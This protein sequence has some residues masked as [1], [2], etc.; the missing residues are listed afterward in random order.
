MTTVAD[1]YGVPGQGVVQQVDTITLSHLTPAALSKK[2]IVSYPSAEAAGATPT[3][4]VIAVFDVTTATALVLGTD[5]TLTASGTSPETLTYSVTRV[6][7]SSASADADTARVTYR[8]G[9]QPS[10]NYNLGEFQGEAGAAPAGTAFKGSVQPTTG[11]SA[12]GIGEQPAGGSLTDPANA[13]KG[14]PETGSPGSEY[15]VTR[16]VP[17]AFGWPSGAPDTEGVYGGGLPSSFTPVDTSLT[18]TLDTQDSGGSNLVPSMYSSPPGY[19]APSAGVAGGVKET[20][21][22]EILGN[23]VN[24]TAAQPGSGYAA[25]QVDTGYIGSPAAPTALASQTDTVTAAQAATP[26]Y[27]SKLGV[28]PSSIVVSDTTTPAT[29]VLNTDYTVTTSGDGGTT[30][31]YIT[32][33]TGT[34]FTAS[35]NVSITYSWGDSTYWGSNTPAAPPAAPTM[36]SASAVNRGALVTWAPPAGTTPVDFYLLAAEDLGTMYVPNTGMPIEYGQPSPSGGGQAGEPTYQ[37]DVVGFALATPTGLAT[38]TVGTAGSTHYGY[39]V[40]AVGVSGETLA[41]AEVQL[42]TGNATLDGT[43]YN[44]LAW[45]A[46]PGAAGYN[47]YGRTQGAELK[48]TPAPITVLVFDD[49]GTVTPAGALPAANTT[50]KLSKTG[51]ITPPGQVIVRD[52]VSVEADPMQPT[53]TVLEYGY[54]YTI[55]QAGIGPWTAYT[56]SRAAG[57]VNSAIGDALIAEYWW[58]DP[59]SVSAVFTQGL[60]PNTPVI[61]KPDG[62]TPYTQGYRFRVAAGNKAGLG[63]WSAWSSYVVP[64]NYNEAQPGHEGSITVGTGSLDPA[65][66]VNPIYNPDGTVKAGTGLGG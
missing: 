65:N 32:L 3:A 23:Q 25:A 4:D 41:C 60:L 30:A 5:Y 11:S 27:L 8:Y 7:S 44:H 46:V 1:F 35:D 59:S 38:S 2:G 53:G 19:R 45:N 29:L 15:T 14:G 42:N 66:A 6:N 64:L 63:P 21:L 47:V 39:R 17:G 52:T 10:V 28:I 43:N 58:T 9:I 49:K 24:A 34:N 18:K 61:Y 55:A 33:S 26:Y 22:T 40:S 54:D 56:V 50:G 13:I 48:M 57:S 37:A 20:T 51:I 12:S 31:S 62:T 16:T 36:S